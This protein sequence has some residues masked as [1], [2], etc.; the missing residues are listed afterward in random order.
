MNDLKTAI[1]ERIQMYLM[2]REDYGRINFERLVDEVTDHAYAAV[3]DWDTAQPKEVESKN[4]FEG[5]NASAPKARKNGYYWI[6]PMKDN[7]WRPAHYDSE[8]KIFNYYNETSLV[9]NIRPFQTKF[10]HAVRGT[11]IEMAEPL[12][13]EEP[14]RKEGRY[15]VVIAQTDRITTATYIPT[16]DRW[17]IAHQPGQVNDSFFSKIGET[18][19]TLI[20]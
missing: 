2:L 13:V 4:T 11:A 5:V 1:H 12:K 9:P 3:K 7:E 20:S 6:Q 15:P 18:P 8:T 14:K 17:I 10:P 16:V 19:I